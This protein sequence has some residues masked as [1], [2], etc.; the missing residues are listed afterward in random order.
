[1]SGSDRIV[2][3]GWMVGG[4]YVFMNWSPINR[5]YSRDPHFVQGGA[6]MCELAVGRISFS[7]TR[8]QTLLAP[9]KDNFWLTEAKDGLITTLTPYRHRNPP[10][11]ELFFVEYE[12]RA[13]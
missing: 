1:M 9:W 7:A 13:S 3:W 8:L 11:D 12:T 2:A 10:S 5:F 4:F 6:A